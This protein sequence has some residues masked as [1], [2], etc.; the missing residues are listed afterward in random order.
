MVDRDERLIR[1]VTRFKALKLDGRW[2]LDAVIPHWHPAWW[3]LDL[4]VG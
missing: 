3:P 1:T 2:H 4:E